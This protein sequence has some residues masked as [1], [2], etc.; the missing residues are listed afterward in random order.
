M[1]VVNLING[2]RHGILSEESIIAVLVT[3]AGVLA[4]Y[5]NMPTSEE[6]CMA[7]GEMRARKQYN[8]GNV[9]NEQIGEIEEEGEEDDSN[10]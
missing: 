9:Y 8:K 3:A 10:I 7:T 1:A 2:I 5:F 4:W 6:N